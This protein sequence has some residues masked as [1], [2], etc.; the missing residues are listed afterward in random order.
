MKYSF[1]WAMKWIKA[2][3]ILGK[4][5]FSKKKKK[6]ILPCPEGNLIIHLWTI[7]EKAASASKP[8]LFSWEAFQQQTLYLIRCPK[9]REIL[10]LRL[11]SNEPKAYHRCF[12]FFN[13]ILFLSIYL[14]FNITKRLC[15]SKHFF[16]IQL[17]IAVAKCQRAKILPIRA[18]HHKSY[19]TLP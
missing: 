16:H 6:T 18:S 10:K 15:T 8:C 3:Q 9:F 11:I 19:L 5:H 7:L 12:I 14:F 1:F 13:L 2:N 4:M 17:V